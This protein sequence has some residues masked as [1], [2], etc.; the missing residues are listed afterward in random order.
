MRVVAALTATALVIAR[1]D[2]EPGRPILTV[3][4]ARAYQGRTAADESEEVAHRAFLY[5]CI[6]ALPDC[7]VVDGLSMTNALETA[8]PLE[9]LRRRGTVAISWD[10]VYPDVCPD[11]MREFCGLPAG[12]RGTCLLLLRECLRL[13]GFSVAPP[14]VTICGIDPG[15]SHVGIAVQRS[16]ETLAMTETLDVGH[17][18][19]L[20][21]SRIVQRKS[22][23][24]HV[25]S[26]RRV[27]DE[28]D[29]IRLIARV[30]EIWTEHKVDRVVLEWVEHV[31]AFGGGASIGGMATAIARAQWVGG[32]LAGMALEM[33]LDVRYVTA[34]TWVARVTKGNQKGRRGVVADVIEARYPELARKA[35]EH[36]RD[37]VGLCLYDRLLDVPPPRPEICPPKE[38]KEKPPARERLPRI[39]R[40]RQPG[41]QTE[42]AVARAA[43]GCVCGTPRH[44]RGCVL[45]V[46]KVY[47]SRRYP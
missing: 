18:E 8:D 20:A 24:Q 3:V 30:R 5:G 28:N 9:D 36:E 47:K 37:A 33:G 29:L 19:H 1:D 22:G 43:A 11:E 46:P 38:R 41:E 44:K 45:F 7:V 16:D 34:R 32:A 13:D 40:T 25:I 42:E 35:D 17:E 4:D 31:R 26:K 12:T 2:G 27:I 10:P 39:R 6:T 21:R 15:S 14:D 23:T